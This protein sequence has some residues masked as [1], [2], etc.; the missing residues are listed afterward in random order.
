MRPLRIMGKVERELERISLNNWRRKD[1]MAYQLRDMHKLLTPVQWHIIEG[2]FLKKFEVSFR[3]LAE[4][5]DIDVKQCYREYE[6]A[7][8][9][10]REYCK[11]DRSYD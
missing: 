2:R 7:L 3:Q 11:G 1:R 8:R 5:L 10:C 4:E 9:I 6:K